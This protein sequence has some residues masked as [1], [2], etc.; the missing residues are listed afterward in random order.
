M[1][2]AVSS[3]HQGDLG[4]LLL[5][6]GE[7]NRI[8]VTIA[9]APESASLASSQHTAWMLVNILARAE[10]YVERLSIQCREGIDLCG[11][12]VPLAE[13]HHDL[14]G[15][16]ISGG[17]AIG[18]LPVEADAQFEHTI[19]VGAN[20]AWQLA[21]TYAYSSGW[22][23]GIS[24]LP[25]P[26]EVLGAPSVLPFGPY[27][28]ACIAAGEVF[29]AA[30]ML[31]DQ[32]VAPRSIF[33]SLWT[34]K[35]EPAPTI[36]G[37]EGFSVIL[38]GAL[39]GVG[40][41]GCSLIHAIWACP[42]ITGRLI[43]AD[44]DAKGLDVTNLNRYALFGIGALGKPKASTAAE[45]ARDSPVSWDPKDEGIETVTTPIQRIISAVDKNRSRQG[46]Q[47]RYPARILSG[48]TLNLR[49]EVLRCGPPGVGA[50]LRCFNPPE[51]LEPDEEARRR[52]LKAPEEELAQLAESADITLLEAK[53]WLTT[54]QCGLAGERLLPY[55][56][57]SEGESTF[58]V[59]FVSVMAGT[60]LASELIKDHL[61]ADQP[62]SGK[63]QRAVFQFESPLARTNRASAYARDP[64][65]PMCH[66]ATLASQAWSTRYEGL[67]PKR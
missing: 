62:L 35:A 64:R 16:L 29:K 13:R 23:G 63:A 57:R 49:A 20:K 19:V 25:I 26:R 38:D 65:C 1:S 6:F 21:S 40:A 48:S 66:P 5:P 55:L 37:P 59:A 42:D 11:R 50:C 18:V 33:Y 67:A 36:L 30:R 9:V 41:V 56:R 60:M 28:A 53:E 47:G 46:I 34:H 52:L 32:F 2:D 24:D 14:R 45:I 12:V 31:P 39:A 4:G 54:G 3:R 43:L 8:S 58:A 7:T 44:N 27:V 22:C 51:R 17:A 15:A 10:G 61:G